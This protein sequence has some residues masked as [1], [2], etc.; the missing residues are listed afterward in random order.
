MMSRKT[1]KSDERQ[2]LE[3]PAFSHLSQTE[4][5][6]KAITSPA[7]R[8]EADL[9]SRRWRLAERIKTAYELHFREM[10]TLIAN[11]VAYSAK[12]IAERGLSQKVDYE[13]DIP[14]PDGLRYD[15]I[16][17]HL[18]QNRLELAL[19]TMDFP[20]PENTLYFY[21]LEVGGIEIDHIE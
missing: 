7:E 4:I 21:I 5:P 12:L 2:I 16:R 19:D 14:A 15:E 17:N 13:Y 20:M 6:Q 8:I 3:Y 18:V 1:W 9:E 10:Q 11:P